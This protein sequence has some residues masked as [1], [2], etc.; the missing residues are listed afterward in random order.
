VGVQHG[1]ESLHQLGPLL[2]QLLAAALQV[3]HARLLPGQS[4]LVVLSHLLL[5]FLSLGQFHLELSQLSGQFL[6]VLSIQVLQLLPV[7]LPQGGLVLQAALLGLRQALA[8]ALFQLQGQL[9][10]QLDPLALTP[11]LGVREGES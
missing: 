11:R 10:L 8:H 7:M 4:E 5:P 6:L 9:R 3:T 1:L 2:L